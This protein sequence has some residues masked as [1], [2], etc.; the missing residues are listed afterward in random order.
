MGVAEVPPEAVQPCV[1][2]IVM[3]NRLVLGGMRNGRL[4]QSELNDTCGGMCLFVSSMRKP[5]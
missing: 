4:T 1:V 2:R 5:G 3:S